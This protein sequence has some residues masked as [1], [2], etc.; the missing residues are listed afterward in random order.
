MW[1]GASWNFI[2]W[3]LYFGIILVIEK[4]TILKIK[5]KIPAALLHFYA[6]AIV[7]MG[8]GIFYFDDFMRLRDFF[9]VAFGGG[10]EALSFAD[11]NILFE[12][13]WLFLAAIL[14]AAPL[15]GG[16]A[17]L[18]NRLLANHEVTRQGVS[19][20]VRLSFSLIILLVSIALLVGATNNAFLYTRF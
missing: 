20:A 1:H 19:L 2:L 5:D 11:K 9:S 12:K 6:V 8:F 15:R 10:T 14:L 13:F 7:V 4:H 18:S 17:R 3:G 16:I